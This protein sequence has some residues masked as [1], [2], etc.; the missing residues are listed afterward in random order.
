MNTQQI[1]KQ[2]QQIRNSPCKNK[3]LRSSSFDIRG[4]LSKV[5][6]EAALEIFESLDSRD[7]D[8]LVLKTR[9]KAITNLKHFETGKDFSGMKIGETKRHWEFNLSIISDEHETEGSLQNEAV[10]NKQKKLLLEES[11]CSE[12]TSGSSAEKKPVPQNWL[13][14]SIAASSCSDSSDFSEQREC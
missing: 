14:E 9:L 1:T 13:V 8:L 10:F 6:R 11:L 2:K 5:E 4:K 12:T 7:K 3:L